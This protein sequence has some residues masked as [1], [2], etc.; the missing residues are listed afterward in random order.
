VP[1]EV[2]EKTLTSVFPFVMVLSAFFGTGLLFMAVNAPLLLRLTEGAS[3]GS[4]HDVLASIFVFWRPFINADVGASVVLIYALSALVAGFV[5]QPIAIVVATV[6]GSL[7]AGIFKVGR[8]KYRPT[9]YAAPVLF[10]NGYPPFIDWLH[11]NRV[12]KALWEWELFN[13]Y[14]YAGI[15]FNIV[16]SSCA[17]WLLW[18]PGCPQRIFLVAMSGL[19]VF[20]SLARSA[21]LRAIHDY[22][23]GLAK[24]KA[25]TATTRASA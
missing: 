6:A 8:F 10:G 12:A 14:M 21:A 15:A 1:E 22:Y 3:P 7:V 25:L 23:S 5:V 24:N 17:L 20:Y 11:R 18:L 19:A 2:G 13:H 4:V 9:F 16:V